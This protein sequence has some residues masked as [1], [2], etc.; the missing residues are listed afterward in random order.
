MDNTI[1]VADSGPGVDPDD[2][3]SV[4]ST[5]LLPPP[6]WPWCGLVPLPTKTGLLVNILIEYA[7]P[8]PYR[9]LPRANFIIRFQGI[10]DG[11]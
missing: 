2:E 6:Q 10:R 5:L 8:G 4:V 3:P 9:L 11:T 7:A 1:I